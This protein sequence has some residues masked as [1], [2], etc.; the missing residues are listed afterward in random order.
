M[1]AVRFGVVKLAL[2]T[3]LR[4]EEVLTIPADCLVWDEHLDIVTGPPGRNGWAASHAP[5]DCT[6]TPRSYIDGALKSAC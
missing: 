1:D 4:I 2:F 5:C 6:I 3:G